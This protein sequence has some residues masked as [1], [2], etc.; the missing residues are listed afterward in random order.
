MLPPMLAEIK[1]KLDA[2]G[3]SQR[4][5]REDA[6]LAELNKLDALFEQDGT[7]RKSANFQESR[8]VGGPS[9]TCSCCGK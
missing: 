1:E 3:Y 4:S 5:S 2:K 7:A 6:L 9:G 8:I